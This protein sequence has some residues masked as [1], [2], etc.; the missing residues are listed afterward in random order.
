M[1]QEIFKKSFERFSNASH[2]PY[3]NLGDII[4][5]E[6]PTYL[7]GE[8]TQEDN[9]NRKKPLFIGDKT[10]NDKETFVENYGNPLY[11]VMKEHIMVVVEKNEDKV[12]I[13]LF[14]GYRHR[15]AGNVWFKVSKNLDY[16][17][18]NTKTGDVYIGHIYNYQ[19][20]RKCAKRMVRN[21]FVGDPI[22]FLKSKIKNLMNSYTNNSYELAID[23]IS[24]F[25]FEIDQREQFQDLDFSKRLFRF[26]LK[27]RGIKYPNNFHIYSQHL[28]GKEIRKILKKNDN[29][30]VD[31]FMVSEKLSGKKLKRALHLCSGLNINLY[32]SAKNLFG[33]DW[34]NQDDDV[35][36]G[37][38][39]S[40][41]NP[42]YVNNVFVSLLSTEE[43]RRVYD[44]FKQVFINGTLDSYTFYDHVRMYTE[45]KM[46]GEH[47]LKW[48]SGKD[49]KSDFR[50]EHLD[51]TDKLQFYKK[52][53]YTRIYPQFLYDVLS[54]PI[55]GYYPVLLNSSTNY[56]EESA[57]QSNCVKG[58]IGKPSS[59]IVS[60]RK[61]SVD[62]D[63]RA[64]LE[65]KIENDF[66]YG[67]I[68]HRVQ[69]L[70]KFNSHL[71]DEWT[72]VLF[73]LDDIM[74]S[75][76]QDKRFELV[77]LTKECK[78]GVILHS[79]SE[80][81]E[82]GRLTWTHKN[83]DNSQPFYFDFIYG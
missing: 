63:V 37:L 49:S 52:G 78:N 19:K 31:A 28:V 59:I 1:K 48:M 47:D 60:L 38:L 39:N 14:N 73:K 64:T 32:Q 35:I 17:T 80:W 79:D 57:T 5:K 18:V 23:A 42:S 36:M 4:E 81:N 68:C 29:K 27:K 2:L 13:K 82:N 24:T 41:N 54:N 71:G 45:L 83:I 67:I 74:L 34:L 76:I 44:L 61:G 22:N 33:E 9:R 15:Q 16:I 62:S 53:H 40:T 50:D 69:S 26:Y 58:Y 70:G 72:E 25:M 46:F 7:F 77:K 12:T 20:K 55:D 8:L 30:L 6:T 66:E 56:N 65:Y 43:L 51:W 75:S 3:C 10:T 21:Y 11:S